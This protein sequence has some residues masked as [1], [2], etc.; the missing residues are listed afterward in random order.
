MKN[1]VLAIALGLT[2]AATAQVDAQKQQ[3]IKE[4]YNTALGDQQGYQWLH[5]LCTEIGARPS[6]SEAANQAARWAMEVLLD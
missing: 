6:G 4:I 3:T 2:T 1:T 5:Y